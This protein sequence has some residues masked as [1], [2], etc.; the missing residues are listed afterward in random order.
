MDIGLRP[1]FK[2]P[3][4]D[5]LTGA[6]LDN[7]CDEITKVMNKDLKDHKTCVLTQD[8]SGDYTKDGLVN[9]MADNGYNAWL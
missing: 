7:R 3:S 1:D 8:G 9:M 2:T 4:S 6:L 5:R